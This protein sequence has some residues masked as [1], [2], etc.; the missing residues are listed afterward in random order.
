[1]L[2]AGWRDPK[3][4]HHHRSYL[5]GSRGE[6]LRADDDFAVRIG[7]AEHARPGLFVR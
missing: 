1:M 6:L 7:L 4:R 3:S 5:V 2:H